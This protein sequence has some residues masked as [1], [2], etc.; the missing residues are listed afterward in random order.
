MHV[1][2]IKW[3]IWTDLTNCLCANISKRVLDTGFSTNSFS[4]YVE[5]MGLFCK[6][7]FVS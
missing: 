2:E 1:E 5:E 4:S 3:G 7:V 6:Q